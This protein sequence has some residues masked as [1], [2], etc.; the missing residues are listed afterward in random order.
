MVYIEIQAN[1]CHA[2]AYRVYRRGFK[3]QETQ[4][5]FGYNNKGNNELHVTCLYYLIKQI[6]PKVNMVQED[7]SIASKIRGIYV[8]K[9]INGLFCCFSLWN[10]SFVKMY[11]KFFIKLKWKTITLRQA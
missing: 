11:N 1:L 10:P 5:S 4:F 9:N 2:N 8:C 6:L 7:I 3:N